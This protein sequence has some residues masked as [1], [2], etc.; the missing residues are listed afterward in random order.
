VTIISRNPH[1]YRADIDGLRAIAI[2]LVVIF[3]AFPKKL[4]GGFIGVDVFFVISGFLITSIL[5]IKLRN[6]Q[7]SLIDFYCHRIRRIF[8]ALIVVLAA[9][10]LFGWFNL[11]AD[12]YKQLGKHIGGGASFSS[13]FILWNE[14]GYFDAASISKP[15]LHLWSLAIEEQFYLLWPILLWMCW[16][17]NLNLVAVFFLMLG[18]SFLANIYT[19]H[20]SGDSASLFYLPQN[21]FW[22]LMIG[23]LLA[24]KSQYISKSKE[25][26]LT[27]HSKWL[28]AQSMIGFSLLVFGAF[29]ISERSMYPGYW[30]LIPTIGTVAIISAGSNAWLNRICLAHPAVV[31]VG[32]ISFP[33]YLW[34]WPI[35]SFLHI[36][37]GQEPSDVV[38]LI[39][40]MTSVVLAACTYYFVEKFFR[41]GPINKI[42]IL[43]LAFFLV[44]IGFIGCNTY[45]R[46]GLTFR[47]NQIQ[48]RLPQTLQKLGGK[49]VK[50][51]E[52]IRDID[53]I[54]NKAPRI[55]IWGD[56]YAEHLVDGY[57]KVFGEKYQVFNI[58]SRGC[59]P[60]MNIEI[61][62][63]QKCAEGNKEQ[64]ER[65]KRDRP[66]RVV[67][68]A[69]WTDYDWKKIQSSI[70]E[71]KKNGY[72]KID[73]VGPAPQWKESLYKQL[74]LH[75][76]DTKD[77]NIPYRMQ[78]GLKLNFLEIE[79]QLKAL[80]IKNGV[81]YL[82]IVYVLCNDS[83]CITRFGDEP[84]SLE[85]FDG[86]H[87]TAMASIYVVSRFYKAK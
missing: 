21:R 36:I 33:L 11:L 40:L 1:S 59:P 25:F 39:A 43:T 32:L 57:E 80:A 69:N 7:F 60:I 30:A 87:F 74:Y 49:Y 56:S 44:A 86:G 13:N 14:S 34:H 52:I 5:V 61:P 16:G 35:L 23:S 82:S 81:N 76:L 78:F 45:V 70:D 37:S 73:I 3:H 71:L 17:F 79:P 55:Y 15:L 12:E 6:N 2:I 67:L 22:E 24:C 20:H 10:F 51:P 85:S 26:E 8:P 68:A 38:K 19:L 28:D 72:H 18:C 31:W 41:R 4:G 48:F 75:Y 42:K 66:E 63:L 58:S 83:G 9:S 47:L 53:E 50:P 84:D 64:I 77:E 29:F 65:I 27:L 46:D 62:W 54:Q